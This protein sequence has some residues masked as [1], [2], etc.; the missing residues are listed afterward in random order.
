MQQALASARLTPS[1]VDVVEA[2]GTGTTLGDPIEAQAILATYGQNRDQP[3]WL[4]SIKS[5]IGHTQAAAGVAGI[6]KM[7]MAMR[8]GTLPRTLH[9]DQPSPH[10]DWTS[11]AVNLLTQAQPW[12]PNGHPRRAAISSF[13]ISGTNAHLILE[14]PPQL[15]TATPPEPATPSTPQPLPWLLSAKTS[16]ALRAQARHLADRVQ[17]QP[18]LHFGDVAYTLFRRS[19][20]GYRAAVTAST[21]QDYLTGLAALAN[22]EAPITTGD[23][24]KVAYLFTGQGAQ[25][26]GMGRELYA[27]HPVFARALDDVCDHFDFP[28]RDIMWA[29]DPEQLHQTGHTQPALFAH[30]TA[31]H[32]LLQ[33]HGLTPDYLAGHS[34]GEITAAHIAGALTLTDA[35][36]LITARAHLMQTLPPG[37]AML[38]INTTEDQIQPHLSDTVALAAVNTTTSVVISGDTHDVLAIAEH[39]AAHGVRTRQLTVSHAFHSAH[40]DPI[41]QPFHT[42][43]NALTY[44]PPTIPIISTRT[45][46]PVE[47]FTA[48]HWVRQLRDTVRFA[49]AAHTL[50]QHGVTTHLELG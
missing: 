34:I 48:E 4:G 40:M 33:Q 26:P 37:G 23:G 7:L 38:A 41:L 32:H 36:T 11:G 50:L 44:A 19:Q 2:H 20:F 24:G 14:Q 42:A 16:D 49:D 27:R 1:D 8:H 43:I 13:G 46:Q 30:Q 5:N 6:I 47:M 31:L 18:D 39:F 15:E 22:G 17:A 28:L 35:C 3:L 10:V 25:H 29:E 12:Q 45:G 9:A 21:R